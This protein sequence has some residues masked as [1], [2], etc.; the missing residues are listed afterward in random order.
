MAI[1]ERLFHLDIDYF[2]PDHWHMDR[3]HM[4]NMGRKKMENSRLGD[5]DRQTC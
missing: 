2:D 5:W 4:V 3:K 1:V